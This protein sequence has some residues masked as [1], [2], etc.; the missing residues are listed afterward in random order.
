VV[1]RM[2]LERSIDLAVSPEEDLTNIGLTSLDMV[3]LVLSIE[4]EFDVSIPETHITP[5]NFRSISAIDRL[6]SALR[7]R[8]GA[9]HPSI[10]GE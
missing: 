7:Q 10:M 4:S 9:N 6:L 1:R 2:L 3:E 5:A 8:E